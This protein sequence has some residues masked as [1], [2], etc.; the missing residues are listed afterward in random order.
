MK[1][2]DIDIWKLSIPMHPFRIATGTMHYAQNMFIRVHTDEGFYGCGECSAFPVITGETQDTCI[3]MARE[4]ARLWKDEDPLDITARMHQ[5]HAFAAFNYTAKSAFDMTL[6]DIASKYVQ[7]PLYEFLGGTQRA[8]LTDLTIGIDTPAAM[9][10]K[11]QEFIND[12]VQIIKI[13]LGSDAETDVERV[14]Q[15]RQVCGDQII[16][17]IDAN[18]GWS[19]DEAVFVLQAI[20]GFNIEFCEQPMRKWND[21]LLPDLMALSPI[22]IMADESVFDR[23]DAQRMIDTESCHF[24]NIKFAKSGGLLEA[25]EI[26]R[27]CERSH[28]PCMIGGMLESRMALTAFAHFASATN[29]IIFY[30]MDTCMLGHKIDPVSGGVTFNNYFV[31]L[32]GTP[33]IGADVD[34]RFLNE[35]EHIR[36]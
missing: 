22:P 11:A 7:K 32:P 2:T 31:E 30:D 13:K 21:H 3:A 36:M 9:A 16:L 20:S 8:M 14:K 12:G 29:N 15:I 26:N 5:L 35:C 19:F 6:Y 23:H 18:Q 34:E 33:G 28:I 27:I 10:S 24:V 4:F 17:R 1:I 25:L